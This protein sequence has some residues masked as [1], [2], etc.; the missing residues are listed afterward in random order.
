MHFLF[1][2][3]GLILLVKGADLLVTSAS[4]I[5]AR[6]GIPAFIIGLTIVAIGTSAPEAAIGIFSAAR[7]ANQ[8]TLGDVIGSSIVNIALILGIS[9]SILPMK[10]ERLVARREI[11][12]SFAI[13]ALLLVLILTGW[14]VSRIEGI[15]L[16]LGFAAFN[17][18]ILRETLAKKNRKDK[19]ELK[20]LLARETELPVPA[21][22][23]RKKKKGESLAFL[24]AT[25]LIGLAGLVLGGNLVVDNSVAIAE[26]LGLSKEFIGLTVVALGTSLPELVTCVVA[27]IRKE[28]DIA[29]GNIIGSNI[30]NVLFVLGMSSV[31]HPIAVKSDI[32]P[33]MAF[34]LGAT[35]L[36][37]VPSFFRK[38]I[39][40]WSGS[41]FILY[42]IAFI[43]YKAIGLGL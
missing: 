5:A 34:M 43:S 10:V 9:A 22:A 15:I 16:L 35:V 19:S 21:G 26:S 39:G 7:K 31:I 40:R 18:F 8:I 24:T 28:E 4:K 25:F 17:G 37:F 1:L 6:L 30:F 13:Q 12:L 36:L 23:T 32:L 29:V 3:A 38:G 33:D 42:Y 41:V 11:P 2:A 27:A 14:N 20:N